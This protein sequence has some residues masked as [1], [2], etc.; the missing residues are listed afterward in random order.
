MAGVRVTGIPTI[1]SSLARA[2][3]G[4]EKSMDN[5]VRQAALEVEREAKIFQTP[6]VDSGRLRESIGTQKKGSMQFDVGTNVEYA[7]YVEFGTRRSA[8]YPYLGPAADKV[9][10]KYPKIIGNGVAQAIK[11]AL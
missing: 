8:A 6:H 1:L 3:A 4:I 2:T 7:S 5:V 10:Q 9:R 11:G